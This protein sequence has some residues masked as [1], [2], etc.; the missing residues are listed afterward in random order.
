MSKLGMSN[1]NL[2]EIVPSKSDP[3][4]ALVFFSANDPALMTKALNRVLGEENGAYRDIRTVEFIPSQELT[5]SG[6]NPKSVGYL[7][8]GVLLIR[9]SMIIPD[10]TKD[11]FVVKVGVPPRTTKRMIDRFCERTG[12]ILV[13]LS[14]PQAK[15]LS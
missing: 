6:K 11:D 14:R 5:G 3:S 10:V 12:I 9:D 7:C 13:P 4:R 15:K 8:T 1:G 2:Y